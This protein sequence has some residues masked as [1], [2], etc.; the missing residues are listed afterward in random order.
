MA[1]LNELA[2]RAY[3]NAKAHGFHEGLYP[4]PE[5]IALMHSELSEALEDYRDG[6][7]ELVIN[8][9]GKHGRK[10]L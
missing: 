8:E 9:K 7:M 1:T 5:H 10:V 4:V 6:N 2:K 3:D